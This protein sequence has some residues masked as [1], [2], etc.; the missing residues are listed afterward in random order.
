MGK[1]FKSVKGGQTGWTIINHITG[2]PLALPVQLPVSDGMQ[3]SN[4][5]GSCSHLT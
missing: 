2:C 1:Q 4:R 5:C 3:V